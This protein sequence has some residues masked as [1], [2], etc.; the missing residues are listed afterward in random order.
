LEFCTPIGGT[1][2]MLESYFRQKDLSICTRASQ[3]FAEQI[4]FGDFEHLKA[5]PIAEALSDINI[6]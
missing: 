3:D 5:S 4:V 2:T 6:P 1:G